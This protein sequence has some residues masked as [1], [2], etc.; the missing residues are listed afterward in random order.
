MPDGSKITERQDIGDG[1]GGVIDFLSQYPQFADKVEI[2]KASMGNDTG[3]ALSS[4]N[5]ETML[6][7]EAEKHTEAFNIYDSDMLV[8]KFGVENG[9]H[10]LVYEF[11]R[12]GISDTEALKALSDYLPG[13]STKKMSDDTGIYNINP[14]MV[15]V[16]YSVDTNSGTHL[17]GTLHLSQIYTK[18]KKNI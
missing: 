8:N 7:V 2:L 3:A 13:H 12:R 9:W 14:C 16:Q 4:P 17:T 1:F 5:D 15:G 6:S 10:V 11:M 18:I